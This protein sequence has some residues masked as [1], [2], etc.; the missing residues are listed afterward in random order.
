MSWTTFS[1][2]EILFTFSLLCSDAG[3]TTPILP[4][5]QKTDNKAIV[6]AYYPA[7][8]LTVKGCIEA[9]GL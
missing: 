2:L 5:L 3:I 7:N 8:W 1:N 6:M 9:L 4:D